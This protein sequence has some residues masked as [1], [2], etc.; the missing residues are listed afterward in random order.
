MVDA[1]TEAGFTVCFFD[2]SLFIIILPL[3]HIYISPFPGV[4]DSPD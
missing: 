4:C 3:L 1:G 2:F